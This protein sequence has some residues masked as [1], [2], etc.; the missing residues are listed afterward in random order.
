LSPLAVVIADK[1]LPRRAS[2]LPEGLIPHLE[3]ADLILHAGDLMDP[4][5]LDELAADS[6]AKL[7][8][9]GAA[10]TLSPYAVGGRRLATQPLIVDFLDVVTR[11]EKDIEFRLE[12]L[13][14]PEH[15]TIA[16]HTIG[17]L[18]IGE[19]TGAIVLAIRTSEG[20]F[21]TTPSADDL[22]CT[23]ETL[24]VLGSRGQIK[25]LEQLMRGM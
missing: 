15:S 13:S 24:I 2:A 8:I 3:R 23:G 19:R 5:L 12:E 7:E 14:V 10:R 25:R 18:K 9:A 4:T 16:E 21:D 11:G 17:E 22:L 6:A 1:H 20:N